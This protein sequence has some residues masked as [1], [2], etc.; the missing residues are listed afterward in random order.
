MKYKD[1]MLNIINGHLPSVK[2]YL[3]GSR[4]RGDHSAASDIDIAL[5]VGEKI[6]FG[7]IGNIKEALGES[8]IPFFVDVVDLKNVSSDMRDEILKDGVIWQT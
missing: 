2:V 3:Y 8:T 6:D 5:D 1:E 7:I 4:A